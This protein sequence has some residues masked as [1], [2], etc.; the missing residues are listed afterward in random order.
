MQVPARR[1]ECV[2]VQLAITSYVTFYSGCSSLEHA[3]LGWTRRPPQ[4]PSGCQST[5]SE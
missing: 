1:T 3:A 5:A 2:A 4:P